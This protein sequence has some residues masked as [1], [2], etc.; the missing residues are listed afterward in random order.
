MSHGLRSDRVG[1]LL[2][3][4]LSLL[5]ARHVRDPGVRG[6][7]VTHVRVSRDLSHA[8]VFYTGPREANARRASERAL[9]R[10]RTWLRRE[11]ARRIQ[12]RHT[13]ELVFTFDDT[14]EREARMARLFDEIVADRN[15]ARNTPAASEPSESS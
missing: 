12:V 13:P 9:R 2:R 7:T 1:D 3:A 10:V 8:R 15:V 14:P 4:E 6:L 5:L 11:L